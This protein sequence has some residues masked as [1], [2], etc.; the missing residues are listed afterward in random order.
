MHF[1]IVNYLKEN[2]NKFDIPT[3]KN[4][5]IKSGHHEEDI[6]EALYEVL[7][8]KKIQYKE[9]LPIFPDPFGDYQ[10]PEI[11]KKEIK[12]EIP[13]VKY[14]EKIHTPLSLEG[15]NEEKQTHPF[16]KG[17]RKHYNHV[18]LVLILTALGILILIAIIYAFI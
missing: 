17:I 5:L 7:D 14:S 3:L 10:K 12:K 11:K 6:N 9:E 1:E 2:I 4:E 13:K 16:H 15:L 18:N 8:T